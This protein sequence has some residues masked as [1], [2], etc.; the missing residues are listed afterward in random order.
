MWRVAFRLQ[1]N[2]T[3][4]GNERVAA[5][6]FSDPAIG[7]I[8]YLRGELL[9]LRWHR[10]LTAARP[11]GLD[12]VLRALLLPR[13]VEASAKTPL[14]LATKRLQ[15]ALARSVPQLQADVERYVERGEPMPF[16]A[17]LLGRASTCASRTG[18][19]SISA[20]TAARR[21]KAA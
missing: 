3:A 1:S 11:D 19:A 2:R 13:G 10:T 16:D 7:A 17:H 9:A 15:D 20:S 18:R 6:F 14:P 12:G 4:Y 5:D 8:P 21:R